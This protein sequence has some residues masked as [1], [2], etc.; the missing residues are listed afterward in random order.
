MDR[1]VPGCQR[2]RTVRGRAPS[3]EADRAVV[4]NLTDAVAQT[5]VPAVRVWKPHKQVAFGR[6]DTRAD[7]YDRARERAEARGYPTVE[8][9]V[10]GRAV[11]YTGTTVAFAAVVPTPTPRRG[12][13]ERYEAATT[14]V[15]RALRSLGVPARRGEPDASFCPGEH[16]VQAR[17]KISG[18]AQRIQRETVRVSGIVVVD[19]HDEL[20]AVLDAVYDALDVPFDL[21]SVGSIARGGGPADSDAV[22]DALFDSFCDDCRRDPIS[23]DSVDSLES[24]AFEP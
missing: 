22:V 8:R 23:A 7:G 15:V 14:G 17:G 1:L 12:T 10:G 6:R 19:G 20:A 4:E 16:S 5:D 11:A 2:V 9:S 21:D 18:I 13:G 3:I 24:G